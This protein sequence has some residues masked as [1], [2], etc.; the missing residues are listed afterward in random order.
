MYKGFDFMNKTIKII[1]SL[2]LVLSL[3]VAAVSIFAAQATNAKHQKPYKDELKKVESRQAQL[4]LLRRDSGKTVLDALKNAKKAGKQM[5]DVQDDFQKYIF[6][7]AHKKKITADDRKARDKAIRKYNKYMGA[8]LAEDEK[9]L[10]ET[11]WYNKRSTTF[12]LEDIFYCKDAKIPVIWTIWDDD[13]YIG[14]VTATFD[15]S[16]KTFQDLNV[17][18]T[19]IAADKNYE[20]KPEDRS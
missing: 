16:S 5:I 2:A 4:E 1:A 14:A 18:L 12:T 8:N 13:E 9:A 7:R 19:D 17:D 10:A 6:L 20:F 15:A 11:S 3:V